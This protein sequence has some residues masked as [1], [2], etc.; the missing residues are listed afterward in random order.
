MIDM[1]M[2]QCVR[3]ICCVLSRIRSILRSIIIICGSMGP[4][5]ER[6]T[7]IACIVLWSSAVYY[8]RSG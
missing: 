3:S 6:V 2:L 4:V 8:S 5:H 1:N 7:W